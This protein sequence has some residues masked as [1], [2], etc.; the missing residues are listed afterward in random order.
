MRAQA[1]D[2]AVLAEEA[3]GVD[4]EDALA[5][6]LVRGRHAIHE[7]IGRPRRRIGSG[8]RWAR[9]DLELVHDRRALTQ[10]GAKAVGAGIA[11]ADDHDDL[12]LRGDR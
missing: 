9:H 12:V 3:F 1:G 5:T 2:H 11:T 10:R 8:V 6:L 7:R 4:R